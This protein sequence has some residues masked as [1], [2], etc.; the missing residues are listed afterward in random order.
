MTEHGDAYEGERKKGKMTARAKA[1]KSLDPVGKEDKDVNNDGKVNK[2]DKYLMNR[3][4]K[5]GKA[6]RTQAEAYLAD[7]TISTEPKGKD[8]VTGKDPVTGGPVDNYSGKEP[9]VVVN[10]DDG[11]K[12][13]RKVGVYAHLELKGNSLSESQKKMLEMYDE[14]KKKDEKE[15]AK[16]DKVS[17]MMTKDS[18]KK[19]DEKEEE[20]PDMRSKYAMI[21]IIKNKL[22]AAGQRDPMVMAVDACEENVSEDMPPIPKKQTSVTGDGSKLSP[23]HLPGG[24]NS[25]YD[26]DGV[27]KKKK[28]PTGPSKPSGEIKKDT[29]PKTRKTKY[30]PYG[31]GTA[32]PSNM[33]GST[34]P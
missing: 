18:V 20:K 15:L 23:K 31:P 17:S 26:I 32:N 13:V 19:E 14:K 1:G 5:I 6:I 16:K 28:K 21:N 22:R 29:A 12:P 8:K 3:R 24:P 9:S 30:N 27:P 10:P 7:G 2:T 25:Q 11:S 33:S 4:E 34:G